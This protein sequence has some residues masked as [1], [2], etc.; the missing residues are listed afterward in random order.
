MPSGFICDVSDTLI[1]TPDTPGLLPAAAARAGPGPCTVTRTDP[2]A[3][4]QKMP[5]SCL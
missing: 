4:I 1:D 2:A 3:E 5:N